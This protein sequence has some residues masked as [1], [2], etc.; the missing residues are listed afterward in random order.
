V[1]LADHVLKRAGPV[2]S[3]RDLVIHNKRSCQ[4]SA[5]SFQ[6]RVVDRAFPARTLTAEN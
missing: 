5:V 6:F 2:L 3:G 1:R 4:L